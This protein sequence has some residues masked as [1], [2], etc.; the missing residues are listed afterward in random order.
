MFSE[1]SRLG[2]I[3]GKAPVIICAGCADHPLELFIFF[4]MPKADC[5]CDFSELRRE[6]LKLIFEELEM[7]VVAINV[8][9]LSEYN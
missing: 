3:G 7:A 2:V 9:W 1:L 8:D 4:R 5:P 6:R